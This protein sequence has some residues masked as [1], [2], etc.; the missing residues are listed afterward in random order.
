[1]PKH[2]RR[3]LQ[4]GETVIMQLKKYQSGF[5]I[6]ETMIVLIIMMAVLSAGAVYMK[7]NADN[8]LNR[9]AAENLE[10]LTKAV[11]WYARDNFTTLKD[12]GTTEVS[13]STLVQGNYLNNNFS[14]KNNYGQNYSITVSKEGDDA[15]T[16]SLRAL[17]TT[18]NGDVI[19]SGNMRKIAALAGNE[20]GYATQSGTIT[21]N[22]NSWSINSSIAAGHLASLSYISA[23]DIVSAETFLRRGK[24]DGHPEWNQMDT[25]LDMQDN[26]VVAKN[27]NHQSSLNA[28]ELMFEDGQQ[29]AS[30]DSDNGLLVKSAKGSTTV[31]NN[32]LVAKASGSQV[33]VNSSQIQ[34]NNDPNS[35]TITGNWLKFATFTVNN[36]DDIYKT[37]D[38]KCSGDGSDLS[39]TFSVNYNGQAFLFSCGK[40]DGHETGYGRAWLIS[41]TGFVKDGDECVS[42]SNGLK[43]TDYGCVVNKS[44]DGRVYTVKRLKYKDNVES[45]VFTRDGQQCTPDHGVRTLNT[46]VCSIEISTVVPSSPL[47]IANIVPRN[48]GECNRSGISGGQQIKVLMR[49]DFWNGANLWDRCDNIR[50]YKP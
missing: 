7:Y 29:V 22:Q 45:H 19:P 15:G 30:L 32:G 44:G 4:T 49:N 48:D 39:R 27:G 42:W 16:V 33:S 12:S 8:T 14:Q 31:D 6:L 21:G 24:F 43:D 36:E 38:S 47:A 2:D 18:L 5:T 34:F 17:I 25:D 40:K 46:N 50:Y 28:N 13:L 9:G 10:Q 1:M 11:Q 26:S 3:R 37:A 35:T 20:A 41:P 23:K